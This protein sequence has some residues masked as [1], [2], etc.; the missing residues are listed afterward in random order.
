M[1]TYDLSSISVLFTHH[2]CYP[3][4]NY[5][6]NGHFL[7]PVSGAL[8]GARTWDIKLHYRSFDLWRYGFP[9]ATQAPKTI[10]LGNV[11]L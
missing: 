9:H 8:F 2:V 1:A 11:S 10:Y 6:W 3:S 7:G 5:T 4:S